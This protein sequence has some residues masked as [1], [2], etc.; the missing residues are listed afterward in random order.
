MAVMEG[1]LRFLL[2]KLEVVIL[3]SMNTI[4]GK[5]PV[6]KMLLKLKY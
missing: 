2:T 6:S 5:I 3:M 4:T 1:I